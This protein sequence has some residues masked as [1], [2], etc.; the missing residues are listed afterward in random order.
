M[1]K[2]KFCS[3]LSKLKGLQ[4]HAENY[5]QTGWPSFI[6][7]VLVSL[8]LVSIK[9][10]MLLYEEVLSLAGVLGRIFCNFNRKEN[11]VLLQYLY[12]KVQE[13]ESYHVEF[14]FL[15]HT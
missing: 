5:L 1:A 8:L 14:R 13:R 12:N 9:L 4:I 10:T 11:K 6:C 3:Y 2:S 7:K 15:F